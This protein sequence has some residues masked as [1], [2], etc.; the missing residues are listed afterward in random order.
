MGRNILSIPLLAQSLA[1]VQ[2][3]K[4]SL[5][6]NALG[7]NSKR[8]DLKVQVT[9][10]DPVT[11]LVCQSSG[12]KGGT[13]Y[14]K[15]SL[16][17]PRGQVRD[18]SQ[19]T[20]RD[21]IEFLGKQGVTCRFDSNRIRI[22]FVQVLE[23]NVMFKKVLGGGILLVLHCLHFGKSTPCHSDGSMCVKQ[24]TCSAYWHPKTNSICQSLKHPNCATNYVH[25][26][27]VI[28]PFPGKMETWISGFGALSFWFDSK[29]FSLTLC[30]KAGVLQR[31]NWGWKRESKSQSNQMLINDGLLGLRR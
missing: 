24:K 31:R 9:S 11:Q 14:T 15:V 6:N 21:W 4:R 2:C 27:P 1:A 23:G 20:C 29:K 13:A 19:V 12:I 26:F 30:P 10:A 7:N 5:P 17:D 8:T 28:W 22:T 25:N 16:Q 3:L 18:C